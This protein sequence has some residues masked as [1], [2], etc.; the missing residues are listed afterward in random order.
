MELIPSIRNT[1]GDLVDY[2]QKMVEM[3]AIAVA[4]S[5]SPQVLWDPLDACQKEQFCVWM[6]QINHHR[7]HANNWRFF[8]ILVNMMFRR[9]GR[10]GH[11]RRKMRT[12]L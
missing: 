4:V 5:L 10:P 2:D 8:R 1:G 7:V 11:R 9:I 3:A 12:G 6:D